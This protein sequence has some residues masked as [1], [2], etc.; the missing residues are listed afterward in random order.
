MKKFLLSLPDDIKQTFISL[1]VSL[2]LLTGSL[3]M[4]SS[5]MNT[6]RD[7]RSVEAGA[8]AAESDT[9]CDTSV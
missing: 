8:S 2:A 9:A 4:L 7:E 5:Y 3:L 6:I 1:A